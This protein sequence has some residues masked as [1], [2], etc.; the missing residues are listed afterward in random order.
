MRQLQSWNFERNGPGL[1]SYNWNVLHSGATGDS[2]SRQREG[3]RERHLRLG[4]VEYGARAP[5]GSVSVLKER[6]LT[7]V[8]TVCRVEGRE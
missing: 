3:A 5:R 4:S 2:H 8:V 7:D 6:C 1:T